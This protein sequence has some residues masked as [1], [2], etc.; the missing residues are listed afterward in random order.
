MQGS[1]EIPILV[2]M[3][4]SQC[5][6]QM[7]R[8]AFRAKRSKGGAWFMTRNTES[9]HWS[10]ARVHVSNIRIVRADCSAV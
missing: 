9:H 2:S 6:P 1:Q 5:T 7:R 4:V 3:R 8:M 10:I